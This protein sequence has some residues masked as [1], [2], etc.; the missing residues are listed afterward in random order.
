M[1]Q[2]PKK[3]T[4]LTHREIN[5]IYAVAAMARRQSALEVEKVPQRNQQSLQASI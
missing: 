5:R 2:E 3:V 4:D 1:A